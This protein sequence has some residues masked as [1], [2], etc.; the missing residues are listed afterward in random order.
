MPPRIRSLVAS[1][2][3]AAALLGA[4]SAPAQTSTGTSSAR[5]SAT[6][7]GEPRT[8]DSA[9]PVADPAELA[10]EQGRWQDA[11][12]EYREILAASPDDRLSLLRIAQAQRELRRYEE[13][14]A[15]LEQA[16]TANAPEA[17]ID[18]ER[19]RNLALLGRKDE[20]LDALD[21]SDHNG[22]RALE[23]VEHTHEFD[24]FRNLS[25]FERVLRNIRAR[26]YPC[27]SEP[28]AR[29][30]DFW[31]GRWE[32][33]EPDGTLVG[34]DTIE[35][36]D[37]GCSLV[38]RYEGAGGSSGTSVSFYLPSRGEWRQV[39]TGSG[40]TL[41]DITGKLVDG[42][43]KME[44]QVEYV[45]GNRVVAFRGSWTQAADGRVRQRLEEFDLGA[46]SWI[47]WFDGFFRRL[48]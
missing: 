10:F 4:V 16:R 28:E 23:L 14:L 30:F 5:P 32:V 35:K 37:G 19:A 8:G 9:T 27:E 3:G 29:D 17:M 48:D 22:V 25:R 26:V 1:V 11:I 36:R 21:A 40:G 7:A 43:M 13:A 44:G 47:V 41:F 33:R 39:W 31:I 45:D 46:Q 15:T 18:L 24:S 12:K 2:I 20:A 38:E 42:S 34:T 6:T